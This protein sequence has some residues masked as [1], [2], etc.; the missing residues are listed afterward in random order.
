MCWN[1]NISLNTFL[2]SIMTL[3]FIYYNNEYT[4]YKLDSFNN[5]YV[6]VFFISIISMQL[7]EYFLWKSIKTKD[8]FLNWVFSVFGWLFI[9]VIQPISF[10]LLLPDKYTHVRNIS[11]IVYLLLLFIISIYKYKYNPTIFLTTVKDDHLY[12]NWL[13]LDNYETILYIFYFLFLLSVAIK[14]PFLTLIFFVFFAYLYIFKNSN[15]GS[16][17]CWVTNTVFIYYLCKILFI[18]PFTEYNGLC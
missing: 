1:E 8:K 7:I 3:I 11:A 5:K 4:Q 14:F 18:L 9:R 16:L 10:L 13:Y 2:F 6:Y 12:W 15:W 17:W